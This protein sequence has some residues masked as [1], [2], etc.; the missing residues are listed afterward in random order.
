MTNLLILVKMQLKEQFNFKRRSLKD[1][2]LFKILL[3]V[4]VEIGKFALVTALCTLFLFISGRLHLFSATSTVPSSIISIVFFVM[5][6][7]SILSCTIGLTKSL[8]LSRDN[9][10]LL[11]LP[12]KPIQVYLS[13]LI[14]FFIFELKRNFSF[15]VP[16][17]FAYYIHA[18]YPILI[19]VWF[20]F[21]ILF[22]S[23]F[24]VSVGALLSIPG[25]HIASLFRQRK[26][27]QGIVLGATVTLAVVALFVGIA[28]IPENIDI[29]ATWTTTCRQIQDFLKAYIAKF[30][31][32]YN[33][34]LMLLGE[35][36]MTITTFPIA[37][38]LLRFLVVL[39]ATV[40]FFG[41]GMLCV[42]PLFYKMA[43][44]PL[45]HLKRRA[46]PRPNR[47][48]PPRIS[49]VWAEMLGAFKSPDRL[50]FNVAMLIAP[51][52]L[53]FLLNKI[54]LAMNTS[55]RGNYMALAFN[56]LIILLL[57]LNANT[58]ASSIYSR[59]G[60]SSYL[61][62]TQ[63]TKYHVLLVAKLIPT[64][65]FVGISLVACAVILLGSLEIALSHTIMLIIGIVA[66]YL[67]HLFFCAELDLMN[68]KYQLYA[69]MGAS[70]NNPNETKAT[71]LAF[72][73]AFGVAGVLFLLMFEHYS[74]WV[75]VKFLVVA[76]A[77]LA[78]RVV[79]YFQ[80][81]KLY[82]KEK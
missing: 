33:L 70:E 28:L 69:S 41:V 61:I 21:C 5:L 53:V 38:T 4:L 54:F 75:F 15:I 60:K 32:L 58:Y 30:E 26:I 80:S 16:F 55:S 72:L 78:W 3:S 7:M 8:Y 67:A 27:L 13:K 25:M 52:M 73:L 76:L 79:S 74:V 59:D 14:I 42:R 19:Y 48:L 37:R 9:A 24:T 71:L 66:V 50:F 2:G 10:V 82:Y 22:I 12:C 40:F 18:H 6:A 23:V 51:P 43:S 57:A 35:T 46:R 36:K 47:V 64:T 63:P 77:A 39:G 45:E 81:I 44:K 34:S 11:T 65:I 49:A 20:L 31:P 17:F 68:P 1:V 29:V 62:K 56:V